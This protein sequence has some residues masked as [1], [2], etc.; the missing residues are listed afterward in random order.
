[1]IK[2]MMK[3]HHR[4]GRMLRAFREKTGRHQADVADAAGISTS[5]LSQIER[6]GVAPSIDTLCDVCTAL[7][8][9]MTELF[10][11]VSSHKAVRITHP[12]QRLT[13]ERGGVR[14]EQLVASQD[15]GHPA[16]MLLI[17]VGQA[18]QVGLAGKGHEGVEMGYI[19]DGSAVLTVDDVEYRIDAGDSVT[20]SSH[21][22]HRIANTGQRPFRAIWTVLPPHT[23]FLDIPALSGGGTNG[24]E[25]ARS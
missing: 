3:P 2:V 13:N 12:G 20:F 7:D 15:R 11:W 10:A 18:R 4:I 25:T 16:E 14:Y 21:L 6:G 1:M 17:E 23:D 5:M 19:I 24:E 8:L 22:S 9:D